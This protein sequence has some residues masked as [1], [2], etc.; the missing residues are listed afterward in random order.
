M[1]DIH[2]CIR[3]V[4]LGNS[5]VATL[6]G[7]IVAWPDL[8]AG[9]DAKAGQKAVTFFARGGPQNPETATFAE[10]SIQ[11][12]TWALKVPDAMQLFAAVYDL[13]DQAEQ[14]DGSPSGVIVSGYAEGPGQ[15]MFDP[16]TGWATVVG[17]FKL[18]MRAN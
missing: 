10:P 8:P 1:L 13:L 15:P 4:L 9:F 2:A 14:L 11:V 16:D 12:K 18:S 17:F 5:P 7:G 3:Q 6:S